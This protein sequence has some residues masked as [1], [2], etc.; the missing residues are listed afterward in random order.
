MAFECQD[1]YVIAKILA[2]AGTEVKVGMPV[3]ITVDSASAVSAFANYTPPTSSAV[4]APAPAA[5]PA[6]PP[7]VPHKEPK[8]APAAASTSSSAAK[9]EV[10]HVHPPAQSPAPAPK[11]PPAPPSSSPAAQ[12]TT[13]G[14]P[15]AGLYSVKHAPAGKKTASPFQAKFAAD[16]KKYVEKYGRVGHVFGASK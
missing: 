4:T 13:S 15:V 7:T 9:V 11:A 10:T 14:I 2:A 12:S 8:A 16:R 3:M 5:T 1:E 6:T